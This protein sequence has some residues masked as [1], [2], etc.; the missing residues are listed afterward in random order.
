MLCFNDFQVRTAHP[1][2]IFNF[3]K[4]FLAKPASTTDDYHVND[5]NI[6]FAKKPAFL[7]QLN[8]HFSQLTAKG[9][10]WTT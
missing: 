2:L 9:N 6:D 4:V 7:I 1:T 10:L 5:N 3:Q 8:P